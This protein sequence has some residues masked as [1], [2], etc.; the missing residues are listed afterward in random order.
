[1]T[2]PRQPWPTTVAP[3]GPYLVD[4]ARGWAASRPDSPA[5]TFVDYLD[6]PAGRPRACTWSQLHARAVGLAGRLAAVAAPSERVAVLAPPGIDYVVALLASWYARL[7]AVPLFPPDLPGHADR[8]T[9]TYDD[10]A[11]RCVV[12]VPQAAASVRSFVAGRPQPAAVIVLADEEGTAP[13]WEPEPV[14]A[15]AVAY[16]QYS[17]G[18]T[19]RPRGVEISHANLTANVAQL[20]DRL[21]GNRPRFTAVNWLPLFHDMGML[22]SVAVPM[23]H[24]TDAVMFD[25]VAFLMHPRRWLQLLS[26]RPDAYTCAPNFA[27]DYCLRRMDRAGLEGLDL[28][29]VFLWLNGAEPVRASTVARF[30]QRLRQAGT[31]IDERAVCAAYG[32]AEATVFVAGDRIDRT[33]PVTH[34][35]TRL[36]E[37]GRAEPVDPLGEGLTSLVSCGTPAG[38]RVVAV[39]PDSHRLRPDGWVGELWVHGP[40]VARGYWR[41][42]EDSAATFGATLAGPVPEGLPRGPWLRSGD[43]GVLH[44]GQLYVTGRLKDLLIVAGRNHYPQDVEETVSQTDPALGRSA[45]FCLDAGDQIA[46]VAEVTSSTAPGWQPGPVVAAVRRAVWQ[47][48]GLALHDVVLTVRGALPRTTSGK[49]SRTACRNV[50]QDNGFALVQDAGTVIGAQA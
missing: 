36:L 38:Q 35:S 10:C 33:P 15:E 31:G 6:D 48:H 7:I 44:E 42:P 8:L 5:Y 50:Y 21:T 28:R 19:G 39:D 32:L 40:N 14:R 46:V 12:T 4:R 2:H 43:L 3:A 13:G 30:T 25:P 9:A 23:W 22:A 47:R 45:A 11:P 29:G 41:A 16:L 1:M 20:V 27:Y 17:S 24:G 49:V 26:G 37:T 18:S 34:F